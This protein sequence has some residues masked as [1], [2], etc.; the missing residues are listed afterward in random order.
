MHYYLN[1]IRDGSN[2]HECTFPIEF[3]PCEEDGERRERALP[4]DVPEGVDDGEV[5]LDG[6]GEGEVDAADRDRSL[7]YN[8]H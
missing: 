8:N 1:R 2:V 5:A 7:V 4:P 6:D 3:R